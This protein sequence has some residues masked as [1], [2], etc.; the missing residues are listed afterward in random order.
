MKNFRKLREDT[1]R[2]RYIQKDVFQEGDVIMSSVTGLK[3]KIH[4]SGVNYVIAITED[5]EMF[6]AWVRDI[7]SIKSINKERNNNRFF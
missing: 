6:R 3:G 7:R 1:G 5:G 4:R 2:E